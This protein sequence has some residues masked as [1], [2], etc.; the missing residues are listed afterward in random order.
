MVDVVVNIYHLRD[1][2]SCKAPSTE[3]QHQRRSG[4]SFGNSNRWASEEDAYFVKQEPLLSP[5]LLAPQ[6]N[7]I[8]LL[9]PH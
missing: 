3:C 6:T 9:D 7:L 5:T 2:L 1:I 4:I 8:N